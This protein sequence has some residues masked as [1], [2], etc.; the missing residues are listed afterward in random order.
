[1][2]LYIYKYYNINSIYQNVHKGGPTF[3]LVSLT[4]TYL[5]KKVAHVVSRCTNKSLRRWLR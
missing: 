4:C 3:A 2:I 5:S 1:M